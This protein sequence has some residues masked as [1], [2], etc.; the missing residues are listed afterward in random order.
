MVD[1]EEMLENLK[2]AKKNGLANEICERLQPFIVVDE[3]LIP[4]DSLV[5]EFIGLE[6]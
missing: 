1:K 5:R 2:D 6:K 4:K 3:K